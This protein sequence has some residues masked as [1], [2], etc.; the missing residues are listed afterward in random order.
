MKKS[1]WVAVLLALSMLFA[2]VPV[3]AQEQNG[4]K[5]INVMDDFADNGFR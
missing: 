4:F 1:I 3:N 5:K 2:A